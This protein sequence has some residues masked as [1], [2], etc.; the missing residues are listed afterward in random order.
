[1]LQKPGV[2]GRADA[3]RLSGYTIGDVAPPAADCGRGPPIQ[4]TICPT[5]ACAT[6][7]QAL[8]R[9]R[10]HACEHVHAEH[11]CVHA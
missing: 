2:A 6:D 3:G 9:K 8:T 11:T 5:H 4:N 10:A 7:M 1:M